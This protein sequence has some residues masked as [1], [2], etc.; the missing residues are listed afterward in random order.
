MARNRSVIRSSRAVQ[1][2]K[3]KRVIRLA[4]V[5]TCSIAFFFGLAYFSFSPS[6][7]IAR[8]DVR[9]NTSVSSDEVVGVVEKILAGKYLALFSKRNNWLY[10]ESTLIE[11]IKTDFPQVASVSL[12]LTEDKSLAVYVSERNPSGVW[13]GDIELTNCYFLDEDGFIFAQAPQFTGNIYSIFT[14]IIE[15]ENPI[16]DSYLPKQDFL[17]LQGFISRLKSFGFNPLRIH[18]SESG[19]GYALLPEGGK[20]LFTFGPDINKAGDNLASFLAES[21]VVKADGGLKGLYIDIRFG[22]K[23]FYKE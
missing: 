7:S 17:K 15:K 3:K 19:D 18:L 14:G 8:V 12:S 23:I 5:C 20:I 4:V 2:R 16:K 6:V 11:M 22:N 9:G 10:P 21:K 13:C 1:R